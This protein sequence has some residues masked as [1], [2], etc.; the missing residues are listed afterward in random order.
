MV[1]LKGFSSVLEKEKVLVCTLEF[2]K[3]NM[4]GHRKG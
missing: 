2:L 1:L 3:E 4:K